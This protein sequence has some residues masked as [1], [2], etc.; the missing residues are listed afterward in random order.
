MPSYER[1]N[2]AI[3][4]GWLDGITPS[5][6]TDC[7]HIFH[8]KCF[9]KLKP[10][11]LFSLR[12]CAYCSLRDCAYCRQTVFS[13]T[14]LFF[15]TDRYDC[16]TPLESE[17]ESPDDSKQPAKGEHK[18]EGPIGVK[19]GEELQGRRYFCQLL[20][21]LLGAALYLF[22]VFIYSPRSASIA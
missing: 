2:C 15:S 7:G 4:L 6:A 3:C 22:Y 1:L 12:D 18:K 9:Q 11:T 13:T 10:Y 14:K 16:S 21:A 17:E 19:V 5:V 8:E 20:V